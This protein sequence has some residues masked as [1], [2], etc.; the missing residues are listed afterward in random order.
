MLALQCRPGRP[1]SASGALALPPAAEVPVAAEQP[2]AWPLLL[3][4][5]GRTRE[6]GMFLA[7]CRRCGWTSP[8]TWTPGAARAAFQAHACQEPLA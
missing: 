8:R 3:L 2:N 5:P 4:D 1:P 6:A 7:C